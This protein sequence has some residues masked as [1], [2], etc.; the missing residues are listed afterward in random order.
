MKTISILSV[1]FFIFS[2]SNALSQNISSA[3]IS[4]HL[5][6]RVLGW[7][8]NEAIGIKYTGQVSK[9]QIRTDLQALKEAHGW[10]YS[11][12]DL[13]IRYEKGER[14]I[15]QRGKLSKKHYLNTNFT[16]NFQALREQFPDA[17]RIIIDIMNKNGFT[18]QPTFTPDLVARASVNLDSYKWENQ[19]PFQ[20]D[21]TGLANYRIRYTLEPI[22]FTDNISLPL[23]KAKASFSNSW[24]FLTFPLLIFLT[25]LPAV[26]VYIFLSRGTIY[27]KRGKITLKPLQMSIICVELHFVIGAGIYLG[28]LDL[29]ASV[30]Q[31]TI[32]GYLLSVV[33]LAITSFLI[34]LQVSHRYEKSA[35]GTTWSFRENLLTNL[36]MMVLGSPLLLLPFCYF[37]TQKAFP[38]LP[39]FIFLVLLLCQY[40]LLT[41]LFGCVIPFA[42][43]WIWKGKPLADD[44][45]RQR[46]HQL[47]EKA[48]IDYRDI[49]L[50][51][52]QSSKLANAW[53]AGILPKW[54]SVFL[55][56]YLLE[57]LR[58]N[59]IETIFAHELGHLKHKHLLKQVAWVV[60]GFGG[61]L[62]LIRLSLF[63]FGFFTGIPA[64]LYWLLFASVNFGVILLL[65]QFGLMRFWR[66][67]E[68]EA[69]AYA[70]ELTQQPS[71]FLQALR[72]L[73]ELNDAPED[74]DKFN[75]M[76]STHPD[77]KARAEA[78]E[79]NRY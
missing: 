69:D 21:W 79:K 1:C 60:L 24:F 72:K 32:F 42:M 65:V 29:C 66:R 52:T 40:A 22:H 15:W 9:Q 44:T 77:F 63:L 41:L 74:L 19:L 76:L 73:I 33:P 57:H 10:A 64:W 17:E 61:Q 25:L 16:L 48:R 11:E 45:L 38:E 68:F 27:N 31:N 4:V 12:N 2:I 7:Q 6:F 59:E 20:K 50:L 71:V 34:F 56:D 3:G 5:T 8:P 53:V 58:S 78:I 13:E 49:I 75:E 67:M 23:L 26:S 28:Y 47:A 54:R 18:Y 46:L 37:G 30:T 70:I 14:V 55:T 36:R 35:R 62:A 51:Q 39:F 43:R